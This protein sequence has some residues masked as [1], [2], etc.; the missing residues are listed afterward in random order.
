MNGE[1]ERIGEK[2]SKDKNET[3]KG[4]SSDST[5]TDRNRKRLK[6]HPGCP[7]RDKSFPSNS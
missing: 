1:N 4:S 7:M 5:R 2:D 3:L 6:E